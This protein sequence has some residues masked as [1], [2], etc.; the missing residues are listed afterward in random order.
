MYINDSQRKDKRFVAIFDDGVKIHFG[1]KN[2]STYINNHSKRLRA[3][4][5]NRDRV[6]EDFNN[7]KTAGEIS[8]WI[9]WGDD[10]YKHS[11]RGVRGF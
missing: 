2:G 5:I 9:L 3:N 7:P 4:Y 11:F 10:T 1:L 6:N 8:R